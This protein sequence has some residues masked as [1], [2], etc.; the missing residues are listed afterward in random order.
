MARELPNPTSGNAGQIPKVQSDGTYGLGKDET[1][2]GGVKL[3]SPGEIQTRIDEF[4]TAGTTGVVVLES[5]SVYDPGSTIEVK[6]PIIV[7]G[8]R[9]HFEPSTDQRLFDVHPHGALRNI[10][11]DTSVNFSSWTSNIIR[12]SADSGSGGSWAGEYP[13]LEN[14]TLLGN[15]SAVDTP[16]G[17]FIKFQSTSNGHVTLLNN[18]GI[19]IMTTETDGL[20]GSNLAIGTGIQLEDNGSFLNSIC[21]D[22]M[23]LAGCDTCILQNG[24]GS[25][26]NAHRFTNVIIQPEEGATG[27]SDN[28]SIGWDIQLGGNN[29]F[30]GI[31][32]DNTNWA[33]AS[34]RTGS[35][36]GNFNVVDSPNADKIRNT[37]SKSANTDLFY[38]GAQYES[39]DDTATN[40][41]TVRSEPFQYHYCTANNSITT[42]QLPENPEMGMEVYVSARDLTNEVRVETT[43][44]ESIEGAPSI[45]SNTDR[46]TLNSLDEVYTF[47]WMDSA[48]WA[49]DKAD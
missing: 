14:V 7:D 45:D 2:V 42:V 8:R 34:V 35:G 33:T 48:G 30:Q 29:Y 18:R 13:V 15:Q 23:M 27:T 46:F 37:H 12:C 44:G 31:M 24:T 10:T 5:D 20:S 49:P 38:R 1:G 36:A 9:A 3:A 21:F 39:G 40:N 19:Y 43:D 16:G 26:N 4:D 47:R 6:K 32:W 11:I 17:T 25:T 22:E 41:E 28:S